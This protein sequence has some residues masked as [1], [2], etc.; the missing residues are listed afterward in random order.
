[1]YFEKKAE[2]P[3]SRRGAR[4]WN[5]EGMGGNA[6]WNFQS[7]GGGSKHGSHPWLGMDI[8]WNCPLGDFYFDLA[9]IVASISFYSVY[10][11]SK[12]K[13]DFVSFVSRK[14]ISQNLL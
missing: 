9:N 8:F 3:K 12:G 2:I 5:S 6:F 4:L 1:M 14:M 13:V 7:Q 10:A 11:K